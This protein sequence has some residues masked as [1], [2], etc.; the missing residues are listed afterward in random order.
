MLFCNADQRLYKLTRTHSHP[1]HALCIDLFSG[2]DIG[3]DYP[4]YPVDENS[5]TFQVCIGA[6]SFVQ[7]QDGATIDVSYETVDGSAVGELSEFTVSCFLSI[8]ISLPSL[9]SLFLSLS[10][11][12]TLSLPLALPLPLFLPL[13]LPLALPLTNC[14]QHGRG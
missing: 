3:F 7:F 2:M 4:N 11:F 12:L 10:L 6:L 13:H 1:E 8:A 5:G 9:S 14:R